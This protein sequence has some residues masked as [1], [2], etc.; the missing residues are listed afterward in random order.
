MK[1]ETYVENAREI[2]SVIDELIEADS[3]GSSAAFKERLWGLKAKLESAD[4]HIV[5]MGQFKRGKSTFI[6]SLLGEEI[7]PSSVVPLTSV[8]TILRYDD[9]PRGEVVY[10]DGRAQGIEIG[11]IADYITESGNPENIRQVRHVEVFYPSSYLKEGVCLVDTPGTGSTYSHNDEMAY[12]YMAQADAV[13]FMISVDPPISRSELDFLHEIRRHVRKVFFVQN[14]VDYL[15][16]NEIRESLDFN[17][18]AIS[19]ALETDSVDIYPISAKKALKARRQDDMI[20]LEESGLISL[21]DRLNAFLL[22][23]KGAVL[24]KSAIKRL[25][26]ILTEEADAVELQKQ[27][28]KR[29]LEELQEKTAE[30]HRQM[31]IVQREREE[32]KYL[33]AGDFE[34]LV[35]ESLD[36]YLEEHKQSLLEPLLESFDDFFVENADLSGS[37]L[38]EELNEYVKRLIRDAFTEWQYAEEERLSREFRAMERRYREKANA[39]ANR[40]HEIAGDLFGISLH[41]IDSD[42]DMS[43]EGEFWFKLNDAPSDL[44]MFIGLF[45]KSVPKKLSHHLLRK[46]HREQLL[47]LFDRHCG[48]VRY[49]FYLRLQKSVNALR[50]EVDRLVTETIEAI[51]GAIEKAAEIHDSGTEALASAVQGLDQRACILQAAGARLEEV[52]DDIEVEASVC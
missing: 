18:R 32:I 46:K 7:L 15:E 42:L 12:S 47:R 51:Q 33:I 45:A 39:A 3:G 20:L 26:D 13:I 4:F 31:D 29:P 19:A 2:M 5:V 28:I 11:Q 8:N 16:P 40:I 6:N 44:E 10:T 37:R 30:F 49:D 17:T 22:H 41:R 43:T 52:D 34:A 25:K 36:A 38:A 21:M 48:R 35:K 23:E 27:L 9:A 1:L 24:M 14:K 50:L